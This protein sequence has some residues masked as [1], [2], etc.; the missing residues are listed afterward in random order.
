MDP[1]SIVGLIVVFV[2]IVA[3]TVMDG[4]SF[5]PLIGPSS[6]VLVILGTFGATLAGYRMADAK[7]LPKGFIIAYTSAPPDADA[8]VTQLMTYAEAAR[9]EGILALEQGLD[10]LDDAYLRSGLQ[11]VVDGMEAEDV[12]EVMQA[13]TEAMEGRHESLIGMFKRLVELAPTL[14]MIGTVIGLINVLGNLA[15]PEAL[16]TGM[17]LALLTTL[18]GVF[19][20]NIVFNPVM[21]KLTLLNSMEV[22]SRDL[23]LEGILAIRDGASPRHLVERLEAYLEPELRVGSKARLGKAA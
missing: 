14:G 16:G 12:R 18:Y 11:M 3:S 13:E 9:K 2:A 15:D 19:F 1:L 5:G 20:A 10:D 22:A 21:A 7:R 4:N 8:L 6:L 17:A 23:T